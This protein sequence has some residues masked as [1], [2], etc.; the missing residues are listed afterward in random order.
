MGSVSIQMWFIACGS[1]IGIISEALVA[2]VALALEGV[3]K[4]RLERAKSKVASE[5]KTT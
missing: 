2:V 1:V 4:R 3:Q 5:K